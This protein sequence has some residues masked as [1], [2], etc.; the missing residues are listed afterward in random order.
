MDIMHDFLEGTL[1]YEMKELLKHLISVNLLTLDEVNRAIE[2]FPYAYS[3]V[4]DKPSQIASSTLHSSDHALK[5]SGM[6]FLFSL[7]KQVTSL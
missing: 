5:Q 7:A 3:D 2:C 6:A 4:V 1:Q